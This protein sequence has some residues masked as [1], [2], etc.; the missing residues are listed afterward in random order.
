M[1]NEKQKKAKKQIPVQAVICDDPI[2][3]TQT[4]EHLGK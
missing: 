4:K 3:D 2:K 1:L